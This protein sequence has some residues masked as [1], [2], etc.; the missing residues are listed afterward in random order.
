MGLRLPLPTWPWRRQRLLRR[1]S[2]SRRSNP[3]PVIAAAW[4]CLL[5]LLHRQPR[6]SSV[7][8]WRAMVSLAPPWM[9][10]IRPLLPLLLLSCPPLGLT[11]AALSLCP[12]L[13]LPSLPPFSGACRA[14]GLGRSVRRTK[15]SLR[16]PPSAPA[17]AAEEQLLLPPLGR[18]LGVAAAAINRRRIRRRR[19]WQ[20]QSQ[21]PRGPG[22][23]RRQR[24]RRKQAEQRQR[25][26]GRGGEGRGEAE[27]R[28]GGG[29]IGAGG[30][31]SHHSCEHD[32]FVSAVVPV[33]LLARRPSCASSQNCSTAVP[34]GRFPDC[35]VY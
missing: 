34:E 22:R 17:S 18:C 1:S 14:A 33:P 4:L 24:R 6:P 21:W 35:A 15:S 20:Q 25:C 26:A 31:Q 23:A 28:G 3:H 30:T 32:Y 12:L 13:L 7:S 5:L 11:T 29:G 2:S 16:R 8:A 10:L 27:V 19:R 9:E